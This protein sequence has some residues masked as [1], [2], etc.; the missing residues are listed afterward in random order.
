[1]SSP[2]LIIFAVS[3]V[4]IV[5][6]FV[7]KGFESVREARIGEGWRERADHGALRVKRIF[8]IGE[9]HVENIPFYT[10]AV[11]RYVVHVGALSFARLARSSAIQAHRLADFVSHKRNFERRATKSS[12]LKQVGEYKNGESG[13]ESSS[14]L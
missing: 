2:A 9:Y 6:L 3:L 8:E 11:T 4:S 13:G 5:A 14:Q 7:L 12:F 10:G 1:M